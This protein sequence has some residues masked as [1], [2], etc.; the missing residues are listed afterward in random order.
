MCAIWDCSSIFGT[1]HV[2][3]HELR[4]SRRITILWTML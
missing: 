4:C 1:E 3:K 2:A